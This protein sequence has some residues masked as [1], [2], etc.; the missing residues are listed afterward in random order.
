MTS[1]LGTFPSP[2]EE[3]LKGVWEQL[4]HDGSNTEDH[5]KPG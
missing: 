4:F 2:K 1:A 3:I 5:A